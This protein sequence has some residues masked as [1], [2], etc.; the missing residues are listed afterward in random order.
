MQILYK[1]ILASEMIKNLDSK[2]NPCEDFYQFAC[3][4]YKEHHTLAE[5]QRRTNTLSDMNLQMERQLKG[6]SS[7]PCHEVSK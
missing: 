3:G 4:N 1:T 2:V 6:I 7:F 5:D